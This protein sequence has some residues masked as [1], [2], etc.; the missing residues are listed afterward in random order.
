MLMSNE[1]QIIEKT[2]ENGKI[3]KNNGIWQISRRHLTKICLTAFVIPVFPWL[4]SVVRDDDELT[5]AR[6]CTCCHVTVLQRIAIKPSLDRSSCN[7]IR[8]DPIY[9]QRW[10][11]IQS[12]RSEIPGL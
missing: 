4:S 9:P 12:R 11:V 7:Q 1:F 8:I 6:Q 10:W 3:T 5:P 2:R